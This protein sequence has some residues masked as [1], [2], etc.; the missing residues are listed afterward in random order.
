MADIVDG[1]LAFQHGQFCEG[2][3]HL[4]AILGY[5]SAI[6]RLVCRIFGSPPSTTLVCFELWIS[7][8]GGGVDALYIAN[9]TKFG[10]QWLFILSFLFVMLGRHL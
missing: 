4:G 1:L 2:W 9:D 3:R 6:F 5:G 10:I 7:H 8:Y